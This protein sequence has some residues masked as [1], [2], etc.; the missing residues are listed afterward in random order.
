MGHQNGSKSEGL[1]EKRFLVFD[2][3]AGAEYETFW[4]V[5]CMITHRHI[6]PVSLF[7]QYRAL[8]LN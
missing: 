8:F 1:I 4:R 2:G 7:R 3:Q 5:N 6:M